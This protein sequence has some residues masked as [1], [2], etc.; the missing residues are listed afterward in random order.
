MALPLAFLLAQAARISPVASPVANRVFRRVHC[1]RDSRRPGALRDA[2]AELCGGFFGSRYERAPAERD[3]MRAMASL[4]DHVVPTADVADAL[5][6]KAA[7]LSPARDNLIK[8]GLIFA[9]ERGSVALTVPHVGK[10][11]RSQAA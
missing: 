3:Y 1:R 7:S 10:F 4:G 11:L 9:N 5:G 8:K 6:R 2:E